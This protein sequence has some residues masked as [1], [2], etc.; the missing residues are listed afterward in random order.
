MSMVFFSFLPG[1]N[2]FK[3]SFFPVSSH[4]R[5]ERS[6]FWEE[7][8]PCQKQAFFTPPPL[9]KIKMVQNLQQNNSNE[10]YVLDQDH[11]YSNTVILQEI[12]LLQEDG[13]V[14]DVIAAACW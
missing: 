7:S 1:R 8:Q 2:W 13:T 12:G 9:L 14:S 6:F 4:G 3:T 10:F 11:I 5:V